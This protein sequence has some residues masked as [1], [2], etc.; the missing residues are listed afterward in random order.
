MNST[1]RDTPAG[2]DGATELPLFTTRVFHAPRALV[3]KMWTEA[4]HLMNWW[5][6]KGF[7]MRVAQLDLRPGGVFHYGLVGPNGAEM[8]GRFVY[9]EVESPERL[10]YINSFSDEAGGIIRHPLSATWPLEVHNVLT[11][12]EH[13]GKT[14]LT[15]RS[16]PHNATAEEHATFADAHGGMQRGMAGTMDQLERYLASVA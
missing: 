13:A 12:T 1:T 3:F 5:G 11:F 16:V 10:V 2:V 6:P 8:W 9:L 7:T 4:E 15:G 14:T